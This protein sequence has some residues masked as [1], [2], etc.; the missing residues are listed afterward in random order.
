[1]MSFDTRT[2]RIPP[3]ATKVAGKIESAETHDYIASVSLKNG[4]LRNSKK[5]TKSDVEELEKLFSLNGLHIAFN[6]AKQ[7]KPSSRG[8]AIY[9]RNLGTKLSIIRKQILSETFYFGPYREFIVKDPKWRLI[10]AS[11]L[12]D[13]IIHWVL[14]D[15]LLA[16]FYP[17]F[18][19]ESYG[20]I[21][22]RGSS[23]ALKKAVELMKKKEYT[24][25]LQIDFSKYF[26]S[27]HHDILLTQIK[28][29][30]KNPL[31]FSLIE[32][33]IRSFKTGADFD[34]LFK[35]ESPYHSTNDKGM[36]IGSLSSQLFANIYLSALDHYAKDFLGIKSYI[37][38]VDDIIVFTKD[39]RH[40]QDI[41]FLINNYAK[42]LLKLELHP[43]KMLI[44]PKEKGLRFVGYRVFEYHILPKVNPQKQIRKRMKIDATVSFPSTIGFLSQSNSHLYRKVA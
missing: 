20:N 15:Y 4:E 18:I 22:K 39:K 21:P 10:A 28:R 5:I 27:I 1:M 2:E 40:A 29:K 38:Y 31:I 23:K 13:R 3:E 6:K 14:Y 34:Y 43:K 8:V 12:K 16:I 7:N 24:Y 32:K 19:K 33:L 37:R 17:T 30:I 42:D 41:L 9:E 35:K 36:P 26:Y 11:P 25:F 44:C